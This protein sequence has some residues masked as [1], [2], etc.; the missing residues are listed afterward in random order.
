MFSTIHVQ[1]HAY[2]NIIYIDVWGLTLFGQAI[3]PVI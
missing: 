1:L 3:I 2:I